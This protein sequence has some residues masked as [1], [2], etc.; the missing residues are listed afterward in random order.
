MPQLRSRATQFFPTATCSMYKH[1]RAA[2]MLNAAGTAGSSLVSR[3]RSRD[4]EALIIRCAAKS[5]SVPPTLYHNEARWSA[6]A[7]VQ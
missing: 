5:D 1:T 4:L 7:T 2:M 3:S 6:S